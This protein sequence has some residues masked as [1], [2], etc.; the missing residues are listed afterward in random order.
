MACLSCRYVIMAAVR[1][2]T[3]VI[4]AAVRQETLVQCGWG[5]ESN[6]VSF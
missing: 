1:Q 2:E 3:L 4:T 5:E 6:S